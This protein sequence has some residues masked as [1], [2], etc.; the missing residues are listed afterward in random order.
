MK[1]R[2]LSW[3]Y[4]I[5]SNRKFDIYAEIMWLNRKAYAKKRELRIEW[6][7]KL[8]MQHQNVTIVV[9]REEYEI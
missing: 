5:I 3:Y 1:Q 8:K 9:Q 6:E 7:K 2:L 4:T